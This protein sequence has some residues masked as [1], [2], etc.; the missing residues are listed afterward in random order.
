M[1][2]NAEA[3]GRRYVA[4]GRLTVERVDGRLVVAS[5]RGGGQIYRLGHRD[6]EW[7]CACPARGRCSHLHALQLVVAVGSREAA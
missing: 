4:E 1:S 3:K 7:V 2:E 6:G 5:C